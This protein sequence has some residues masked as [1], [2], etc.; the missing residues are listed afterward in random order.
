MGSLLI[1]DQYNLTDTNQI[2]IISNSFK[3][4][5]NYTVVTVSRALVRLVRVHF[6]TLFTQ[7]LG[8][9]YQRAALGLQAFPIIQQIGMSHSMIK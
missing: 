8:L 6:Q 3:V 7:M 5:S 2:T 4:G 9:P 1:N